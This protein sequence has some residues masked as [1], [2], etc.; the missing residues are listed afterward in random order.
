MLDPARQASPR[1]TTTAET[2]RAARRLWRKPGKIAV[3]PL[4]DL[5]RA[6]AAHL[7]CAVL[8]TFAALATW[9]LRMEHRDP[10]LVSQA[11]AFTLMLPAIA[12]FLGVFVLFCAV[13]AAALWTFYDWFLDIMER[14]KGKDSLRR[15]EIYLILSLTAFMA[16][17]RLIDSAKWWHSHLFSNIPYEPYVLDTISGLFQDNQTTIIGWLL[18]LSVLAVY[19]R[20]PLSAFRPRFEAAARAIAN[21]Y[22]GYNWRR[23]LALCALAIVVAVASWTHPILSR[24]VAAVAAICFAWATFPLLLAIVVICVAIII[25]VVLVIAPFMV[26]SLSTSIGSS[27]PFVLAFVWLGWLVSIFFYPRPR[28]FVIYWV[29]TVGFLS[30]VAAC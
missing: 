3:P 19:F 26:L 24:G 23:P 15:W 10:D 2:L 8:L 11:A 25:A 7:L 27:A 20:K 29:G 13:L 9:A 1:M 12:A 16:I 4:R 17:P 5:A 22:A 28:L 21:L 6:P 14:V 30:W 18:I